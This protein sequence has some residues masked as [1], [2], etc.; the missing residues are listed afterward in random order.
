MRLRLVVMVTVLGLAL[1][2][3]SETIVKESPNSGAEWEL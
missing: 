3:C 1:T 2:A